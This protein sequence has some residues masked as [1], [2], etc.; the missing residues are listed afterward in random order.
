MFR[1]LTKGAIFVSILMGFYCFLLL[2]G[3]DKTL[4]AGIYGQKHTRDSVGSYITRNDRDFDEVVNW[5][6]QLFYNLG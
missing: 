5:V 3:N 6:W 1:A 4:V 2:E